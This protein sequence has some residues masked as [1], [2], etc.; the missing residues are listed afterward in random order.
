MLSNEKVL[1]APSSV[2]WLYPLHD[3]TVLGCKCSN[4]SFHD[5]QDWIVAGPRLL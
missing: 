3:F 2:S 1:K 4:L 5:S